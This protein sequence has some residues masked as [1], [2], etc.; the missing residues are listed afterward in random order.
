MFAACLSKGQEAVLH[1]G[2]YPRTHHHGPAPGM[3]S[4]ACTALNFMYHESC[5]LLLTYMVDALRST[6]MV[7]RLVWSPAYTTTSY[8][9][10]SIMHL[11]EF[12]NT[13]VMY[14]TGIY[15]SLVHLNECQNKVCSLL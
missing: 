8:V 13:I 6:T 3:E 5:V 10:Q 4:T 9:C 11:N 1:H 7:R 2:G 15:Q 14:V 12:Q